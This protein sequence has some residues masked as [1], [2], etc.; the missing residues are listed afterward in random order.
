MKLGGGGVKRILKMSKKGCVT[1]N[2]VALTTLQAMCTIAANNP[3]DFK[4]HLA[5]KYR[6]NIG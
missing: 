6:T 3:S 1:N 4:W 2:G 5:K